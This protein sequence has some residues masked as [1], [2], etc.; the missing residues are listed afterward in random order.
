MTQKITVSLAC[1]CLMWSNLSAQR[2]IID[3][4]EKALVGV[5]DIRKQID[6]SNEISFAY[7]VVKPDTAWSIAEMTYQ[8]AKDNKYIKGMARAAYCKGSAAFYLGN[9]DLDIQNTL[10]C[11]RLYESIQDKVG[12][13]ATLSGLGISYDY[14]GQYDLAI[15]CLQKAIVLAKEIKET[16]TLGVA[17]CNLANV[18]SKTKK[19]EKSLQFALE[20]EQVLSGF[21]DLRAYA[22]ALNAVANA[23]L[24]LGEYQKALTYNAKNLKVCQKAAEFDTYISVLMNEGKIYKHLQDYPK[25]EKNLLEALKMAQEMRNRSKIKDANMEVANLYLVIGDYKQAANYFRQYALIKDTLLSEANA[26]NIAQMQSKYNIEKK[27]TKNKLL[28]KQQQLDK[29]ILKQQFWVIVSIGV[30]LA[31]LICILVIV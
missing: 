26:K 23:Y 20:S 3:S 14:Q 28:R 22:Y 29:V 9:Y 31:S 8:K 6:L 16:R 30:F 21:S 7:T 27:D 18:Y 13:A 12:T 11:L 10:E 17:L 4:L 5:T 15:E 19:L 1:L 2:I 25:A 24:E